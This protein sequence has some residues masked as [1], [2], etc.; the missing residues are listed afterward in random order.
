MESASA[1]PRPVRAVTRAFA[2]IEELARNP[3]GV[4][5]S[6]LSAACDLSRST[7]HNLLATLEHLGYATQPAA[8]GRYQ[9][10]DQF[11]ELSRESAR[12]DGALRDRLHPLVTGLVAD[13]EETCYLAVASWHDAV[14]LSAVES[15]R[16]LKVGAVTGDRCALLGTALGHVLLAFRPATAR[17]V[18]VASPLAWDQWAQEI[19]AVRQA[20]HALDMENYEPGLCCV[21]VPVPVPDHGIARAALCLAGP[22]GRLP[23]ARLRELAVEMKRRVAD[24]RV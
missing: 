24:A 2:L 23:T 11:A 13:T 7:T 12:A 9:L 14:Y 3:D 20:G 5:L 22:S 19:A 21:A 4:R 15:P 8:A 10:S 6:A 17:R 16:P 1:G 18:R